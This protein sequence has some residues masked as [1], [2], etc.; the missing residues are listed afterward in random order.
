MT[1]RTTIRRNEA[2]KLRHDM[3]DGKPVDEHAVRALLAE[4]EYLIN[5]CRESL[6]VIDAT[7]DTAT[8]LSGKLRQVVR[9]EDE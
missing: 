6:A 2:L 5:L 3:D 1:E 7:W 9:D 4:R 8:P